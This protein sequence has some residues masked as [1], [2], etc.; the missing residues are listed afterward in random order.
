V[1]FSLSAAA[2]VVAV[3]NQ[4]QYVEIVERNQRSL[5]TML[6]SATGDNVITNTSKHHVR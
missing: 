1:Y 5:G 4:L 6:I 2:A 3:L